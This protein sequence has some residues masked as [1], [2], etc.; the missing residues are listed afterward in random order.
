MEK[1]NSQLIKSEARKKIAL[2]NHLLEE[3]K[4][5]DAVEKQPQ[6][7]PDKKSINDSSKLNF[8]QLILNWLK[9]IEA[10]T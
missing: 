8:F 6:V 10:P 9:K 4:F 5:F 1:I 7:L 2:I 3:D